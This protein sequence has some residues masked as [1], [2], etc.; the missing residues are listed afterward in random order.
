MERVKN[1][2]HA[3][4]GLKY[5][6]L[7]WVKLRSSPLILHD[8]DFWNKKSETRKMKCNFQRHSHVTPRFGLAETS[9]SEKA[10]RTSKNEPK[11]LHQLSHDSYVSVIPITQF[12]RGYLSLR[13]IFRSIMLTLNRRGFSE[14][15]TAGGGSGKPPCNFPI[16]RPWSWNLVMSYY[17]KGFTK[18]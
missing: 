13:F 8:A 2:C 11:Y 1:T 16:W 14:S 12:E 18:K 6:W 17:V 15:G 4:M 7:Y 9:F 10:L 3:F 5:A